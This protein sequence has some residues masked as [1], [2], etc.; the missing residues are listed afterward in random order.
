MEYMFSGLTANE[1]KR[2]ALLEHQ[3][4]LLRVG[5]E[6]IEELEKDVRRISL[7]VI[8]INIVFVVCNLLGVL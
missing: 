4:E 7:A 6:R 3:M 1:S 2:L 8:I 5:H